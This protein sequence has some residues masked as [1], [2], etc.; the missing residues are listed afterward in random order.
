MKYVVEV[1]AP[2][3]ETPQ[4]LVRKLVE[5]F[6]VRKEVAS[7]L[8]QLIPGTVTKPLSEKEA[9]TISTMLSGVGLN[10]ST[11]LVA[12]TTAA[13]TFSTVQTTPQVAAQIPTTSSQVKTA[14]EAKGR[15]SIRSKFL[16]SSILP[17]LLTV[18][19]ALAAILLTVRPALRTQLLESARNPAIAFA[20]VAERVIGANSITSAAA[21]SELDAALEDSRANFQ[22]QNISFVMIT[23]ASGNPLAGWY[24]NDSAMSSIPDTIRTAIQLQSQRAAAR[25]YASS[26][27]ISMGDYN[28]PSRAIE[29]DGMR[30]EV[31]AE[32]IE[33]SSQPVGAVVV[34]VNNQ[35]VA[36]K[37]RSVL[38]S[39][40]LAGALPVIL[41]ILLGILLT[42][43]ITRNILY[44]INASDNIS[45]GDFSQSVVAKSND[46]LGDLSRAVERMRISLQESLERL[47]RRQK[48]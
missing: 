19:A 38:T 5:Q 2:V 32:A 4:T 42:R 18:A 12:A 39:T 43:A 11:R 6:N 30:L 48:G 31:A 34:G 46:E 22:E 26:N 45:R 16:A 27:N 40:F 35:S 14:S 20:S 41:A 44:L 15:S 3:L 8:M 47:Q 23:D 9:T 29:A 28:P 1:H 7:E 24:G 25:A 33:T 37:I 10:V 17:A 36:A 13:S 21:L